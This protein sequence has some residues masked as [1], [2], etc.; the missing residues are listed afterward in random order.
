MLQNQP[1]PSRI[2]RSHI[3]SCLLISILALAQACTP[4][5]EMASLQASRSAAPSLD[6]TQVAEEGVVEEG[7]AQEEMVAEALASQGNAPALAS[8]APSQA[9]PWK[10]TAAEEAASPSP[11]R[12]AP[13]QAAAA[14]PAAPV[15]AA[16]REQARLSQADA[17][18]R[19]QYL[20]NLNEP[21]A[22]M[23]PQAEQVQRQQQMEKML[24]DLMKQQNE[25]LQ[26]VQRQQEEIERLENAPQPPQDAGLQ[27]AGLQDAGFAATQAVYERD[28]PATLAKVKVYLSP[29]RSIVMDEALLQQWETALARKRSGRSSD[30]VLPG[31]ILQG[32]EWLTHAP[33]T[34]PQRSQTIMPLYRHMQVSGYFE[35]IDAKDMRPEDVVRVI[36]EFVE[37]MKVN[38]GRIRKA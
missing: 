20:A 33:S 28:A 35:S 5:R 19:E 23:Y 11:A 9:D 37:E 17:Q 15:P 7:A 31:W 6:T 21:G 13:S 38:N 4:A 10:L 26:L 36:R 14:R 22:S 2:R 18:L 25:L 3:L 29:S 16:S 27:D 8:E 12:P 32:L 1:C 34:E 30:E 24:N